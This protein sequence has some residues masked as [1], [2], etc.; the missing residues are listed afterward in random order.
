MTKKINILKLLLLLSVLGLTA[1]ASAH[2]MNKINLGM[3]KKEIINI[4]GE[5]VHTSAKDNYEYLNYQFTKNAHDAYFEGLWGGIK[6]DY[7]VR[8]VD[9]KVE[10]YGQKGDFDSTKPYTQ[11]I[12]IR[13]EE[14]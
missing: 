3:H 1:C 9:G 4:L 2:K 5:P 10:S 12:I 11:K 14:N 6:T 13:E 7:Y 8:L